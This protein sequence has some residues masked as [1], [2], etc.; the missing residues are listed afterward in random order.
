MNFCA[1]RPR[2][3]RCTR[4]CCSV[5]GVYGRAVPYLVCTG[6]S[7]RT[8]CVRACRSVSQTRAERAAWEFAAEHPALELTTLCP[9]FVLGPVLNTAGS[10]TSVTLVHRLLDGSLPCVPHIDVRAPRALECVQSFTFHLSLSAC[11]L[12]DFVLLIFIVW[13]AW[14]RRSQWWTRVTSRLR[15]SWPWCTPQRRCDFPCVRVCSRRPFRVRLCA[16]L[17]GRALPCRERA[18]VVRR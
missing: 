5:L 8:W 17:A 1:S 13:R 9:A 18:D 14:V 3:V 16:A 12:S 10:W 2:R 4:R 6:V 11:V 7:F 15:T